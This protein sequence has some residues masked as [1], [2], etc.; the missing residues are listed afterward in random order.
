[1][2]YGYW[3]LG[4][5]GW[6]FVIGYWVFFFYQLLMTINHKPTA[7]IEKMDST[8]ESGVHLKNKFAL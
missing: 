3:G 1:M 6:G 4:T 7:V 5:G 8:W 2:V